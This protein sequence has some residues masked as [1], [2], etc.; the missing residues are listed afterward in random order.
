MKKSAPACSCSISANQHDKKSPFTARDLLKGGRA[1]LLY[2]DADYF[3][4]AATAFF[5]PSAK[6]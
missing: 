6:S 5:T 3:A 4:F 1:F 2:S